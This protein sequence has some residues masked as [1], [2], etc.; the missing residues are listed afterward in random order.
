MK[1]MKRSLPAACLLLCFLLL[2][3]ACAHDNYSDEMKIPYSADLDDSAGADAV[4]RQ[5][6]HPDSTYFTSPD[7]YNMKSTYSLTVL[8]HFRTQQQTSEWSCGESAA[9]MVLDWYGKL[10]DWNEASLAALRHPLNQADYNG[11]PGTT[12]LQEMDIFKGVGGFALTTTYDKP[13]GLSPEEIRQYL[14]AGDPILICWNTWGG[15]WMVIIGYDTMGTETTLDDVLI[16]ADPYD[17]SDHNQDG[18]VLYGAERVLEN[19]TT[20]NIFTEDEGGNDNL[21]IVAVPE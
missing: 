1:W 10:G 3:P 16:T 7:V 2:L 6:D 9:L 15:H 4:E 20:F 5:G 21:F 14:A 18:Y 19:F 17:T 13:E 12:L 11:Y 8:H